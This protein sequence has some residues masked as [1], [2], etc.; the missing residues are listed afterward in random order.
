M[1][2]TGAAAIES[3]PRELA[4]AAAGTN[5][6]MRYFGS[7]I[8]TGLLGAIL[9][10]DEGAPEIGVFRVMFAVLLAMSVLA[11]LTTLMI[12]R[13]PPQERT[14][15]IEPLPFGAGQAATEA[16]NA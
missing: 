12:H 11:A 15:E 14:I 6:M 10:S 16:S 8:G 7:I 1:S 2:P 5:S 4:G 13:F 9:S 3:S